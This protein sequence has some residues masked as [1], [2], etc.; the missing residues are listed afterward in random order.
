MLFGAIVLFVLQTFNE[1]EK[2]LCGYGTLKSDDF[3]IVK[4]NQ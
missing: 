4:D 3:T 2:L 1:Y